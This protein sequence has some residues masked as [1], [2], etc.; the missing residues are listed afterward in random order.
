M[1]GANKGFMDTMVQT[2][3][4]ADTPAKPGIDPNPTRNAVAN[5]MQNAQS[6]ARLRAKFG[7]QAENVAEAFSTNILKQ[8]IDSI[9][10]SP[11]INKNTALAI[12]SIQESG[13]RQN[14]VG[15]KTP[16]TKHTAYTQ[17]E[18]PA[19]DDVNRLYK[20]NYTMDDVAK[21]PMINAEVGLRYYK[22]SKRFL[23]CKN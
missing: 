15:D 7:R 14:I 19:L 13:L 6:N 3:Q 4:D 5:T 9:A 8:A 22:V 16:K 18:N 20:T 17:L 21:D 12:A 10:D 11:G 23:W 2:K 1:V